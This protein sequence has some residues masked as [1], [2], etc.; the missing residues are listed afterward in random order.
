[1][2][3]RK[4]TGNKQGKNE[5]GDFESLPN[6]KMTRSVLKAHTAQTRNNEVDHSIQS[7]PSTYS[8]SEIMS[9]SENELHQFDSKAQSTDHISEDS[10]RQ[11]LTESMKNSHLTPD[12]ESKCRQAAE[13]YISNCKFYNVPIDPSVVI[14]LQTGW[15]VLQPTSRFTEGSMLPLKNILEE[16][17]TIRKLNLSNVGMQDSR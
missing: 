9:N 1:M 3:R 6:Q 5:N 7:H 14:A 15:K 4:T 10:N 2:S 11:S 12:E 16:N 17:N 8:T 13:E